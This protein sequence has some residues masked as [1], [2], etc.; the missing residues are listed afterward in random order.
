MNVN[1]IEFCEL[2]CVQY[3]I[4][5]IKKYKSLIKSMKCID[6]DGNIEK[7][8]FV[9]FRETFSIMWFKCLN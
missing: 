4:E 1:E 5:I 2:F 7:Y 3:V 9:Y 6:S 8:I